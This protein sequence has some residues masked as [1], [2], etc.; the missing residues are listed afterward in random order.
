MAGLTHATFLNGQ[1]VTLTAVGSR[2]FQANFTHADYLS[3]PDTGTCTPDSVT[4]AF[5]NI[6]HLVV[7][8]RMDKIFPVRGAYLNA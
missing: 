3:A 4:D 5:M 7:S 6:N 2:D 1:T 8:G